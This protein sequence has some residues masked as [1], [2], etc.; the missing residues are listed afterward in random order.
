MKNSSMRITF[1]QQNIRSS[2][3]YHPIARA[4]RRLRGAPPLGA[5]A[6]R[7]ASHSTPQGTPLGVRHAALP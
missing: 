4:R 3:R 2:L 7:G 6:I 1:P 5:A